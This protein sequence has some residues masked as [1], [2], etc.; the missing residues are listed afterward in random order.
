MSDSPHD[1]HDPRPGGRPR[2]DWS[3]TALLVGALVLA[4][5]T[6]VLL[7]GGGLREAAAALARGGRRA[8]P[9]PGW[10]DSWLA[11]GAWTR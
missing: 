4:V 9:T 6:L 10:Q 5:T 1:H 2:P 11:A 3:L 8:A 7:S